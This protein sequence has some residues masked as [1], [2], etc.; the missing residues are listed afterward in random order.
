M[1]TVI[2]HMRVR[3]EKEN[4]FLEILRRVT[5]EMR[6]SEPDTRVY[7]VWKTNTRHEYFLVESYRNEAA[8]QQHNA[9]HAAVFEEFMSCLAQPPRVENLGAFVVGI[10]PGDDT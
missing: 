4:R 3:P 10:P 7:A 2:L 8:R 9:A 1:S 5:V 6:V